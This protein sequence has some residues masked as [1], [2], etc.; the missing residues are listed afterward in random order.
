MA[1]VWAAGGFD[2]DQAYAFDRLLAR[3]LDALEAS[4]PDA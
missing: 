4:L 2:D 1:A 3:L